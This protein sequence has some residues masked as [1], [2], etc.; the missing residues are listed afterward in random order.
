MKAVLDGNLHQLPAKMG[1]FTF[2]EFQKGII[3]E[4]II[5]FGSFIIEDMP[6]DK[7]RTMKNEDC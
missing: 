7:L 6:Q 4:C 1:H 2:R 5:F 3:S